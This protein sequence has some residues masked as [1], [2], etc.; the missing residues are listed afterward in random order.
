MQSGRIGLTFVA[1]LFLGL[2]GC[3]GAGQ[4]AK[5]HRTPAEVFAEVQTERSAG[6]YGPALKLARSLVADHEGTPEARQAAELIP[7]LEV[8][9]E[10]ALQ[11]EREAEEKFQ[12]EAAAAK[13]AKRLADK[14]TYL[15]KDDPMTSKTAKYAVIESENTVNFGFPY[16]GPQRGKLTI[17]D[18]PSYGHDVIFSIREGQ[19]LCHSYEECV[20]RVRF[21]EQPAERWSA[22]GPSDNSATSIFLQNESAFVRRLRSAEVVRLQVKV[23][24]EGEPVFEFQVGGFDYERY[25]AGK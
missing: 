16:E 20:I 14:W 13:E 2:A 22:V 17:R 10:T 9:L 18:H 3:T 12:A 21:D 23:F 4:D 24:Q 1:L 8:E 5:E 15:S 19:L 11:A 25:K 6:H 7:T